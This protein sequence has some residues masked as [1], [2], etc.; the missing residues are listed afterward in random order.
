MV[1]IGQSGRKLL[2]IAA[3]IAALGLGL[4]CLRWLC[5]QVAIDRCLDRGGRWNH[6]TGECEY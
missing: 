4:V 6:A 2:R 1:P 5:E 3:I